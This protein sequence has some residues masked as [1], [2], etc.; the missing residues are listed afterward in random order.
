M[1]T[2]EP[3]AV[4]SH[5]AVGEP[6]GS[7][8]V[9]FGRKQDKVAARFDPAEPLI[10]EVDVEHDAVA[11]P[12]CA[13]P[14]LVNRRAHVRTRRSHVETTAV[15][16]ADEDR[17]ALFLGA[18]LRP[19][20]VVS[21]WDDL[22]NTDDPANQ[23]CGRDRRRPSSGV[24]L[25]HTIHHGSRPQALSPVNHEKFQVVTI[26]SIPPIRT[27]PVPRSHTHS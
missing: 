24:A 19:P 26:R 1:H 4:G 5:P 20:D 3:P 16:P 23:R 2:N 17:P 9:R 7:G 6:Q 15:A 11:H 12:P 10:V 13:T 21:I 8:L 25:F 27:T 14:I 22:T 18:Q